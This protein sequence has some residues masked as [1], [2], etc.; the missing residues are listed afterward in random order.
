MKK[1]MILFALGFSSLC[2]AEPIN[3]QALQ[4]CTLIENDF[5]R[6]MC[7][8]NV[9]ANKPITEI[10]SS[11]APVSKA[12]VSKDK[13]N[14]ARNE[15]KAE[16]KEDGFGLEHKVKAA[17]EEIEEITAKLVKTTTQ[18]RDKMVFTLDNGQVWR[19]VSSETFFA[20]E[21]DTLIIERASFGSFLMKKAGSNR[22]TR[23][24]RVN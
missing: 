15:K 22:T 7:Y 13:I 9:I 3:T 20:N 17:S 6:L 14:T 18:G 24:K 5:K 4:A 23:V 19:Q 1:T 16:L 2:A 12:P 8:D 21:G 10:H 11:K